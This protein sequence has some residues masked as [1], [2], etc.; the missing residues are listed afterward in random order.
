M[1]ALGPAFQA[2]YTGTTTQV[3]IIK[4][5]MVS[6]DSSKIIWDQT[7]KRNVTQRIDGS[8]SDEVIKSGISPLVDNLHTSF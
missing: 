3:Q 7:L 1:G 8:Q 2:G 6:T 5:Y 4:M